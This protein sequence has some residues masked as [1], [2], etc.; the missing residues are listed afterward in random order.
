M[1]AATIELNELQVT[2]YY[3]LKMDCKLILFLTVIGFWAF[4]VATLHILPIYQTLK[5]NYGSTQLFQYNSGNINSDSTQLLYDDS[6]KTT[7]NNKIIK[8]QKQKQNQQNPKKKEIHVK[9]LYGQD[10]PY[11]VWKK[12][13]KHKKNDKMKKPKKQKQNHKNAKKRAHMRLR[14][15]ESGTTHPQSWLKGSV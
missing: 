6:E 11:M 8:P 4:L 3:L 10:S 9:G 7:K 2:S 13:K 15:W 14:T 12:Y 1:P 5:I